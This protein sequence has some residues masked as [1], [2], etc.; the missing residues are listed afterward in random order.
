MSRACVINVSVRSW[1]PRGLARLTQSLAR[2]G[3]DAEM[4]G[5]SNSYPPGCPPVHEAPYSFKTYAFKEVQ[6]QG[7]DVV[8]W[9]DSSCYAIGP[10]GPVFEQIERDGYYVVDNGWNT[11]EWC[12]DAALRPLGITREE[13]FG[14]PEISTMAVGL[15]LRRPEAREFLDRWHEL[16]TDGV[17]FPGEHTNEAGL[18]KARQL[19]VV[20][21]HVGKLSADPRVLGHRHDQ[22]AASVLAWRLGWQRTPRPVHLDYYRDEPDPR[23]LILSKGL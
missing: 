3:C 6:R 4:V 10:I 9:L 18:E 7:Y 8:L 12:K 2:V 23:T 20:Y 5:W 13:S 21:R 11:G 19:G 14:I 1:Y 15:D 22:T 16:S 17:T